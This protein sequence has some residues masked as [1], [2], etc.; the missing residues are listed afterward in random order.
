[1]PRSRPYSQL[2]NADLVEQLFDAAINSDAT[3]F[4]DL[5]YEVEGGENNY[6]GRSNLNNIRVPLI[7]A[8]KRVFELDK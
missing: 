4:E 1:M 2:S 5:L 3:R 7:N 8:A 6:F